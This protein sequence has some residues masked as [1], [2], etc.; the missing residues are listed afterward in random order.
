[1]LTLTLRGE[2]D[3]TLAVL[4]EGDDGRSR[5]ATLGILKNPG[6]LS[7]GQGDTLADEHDR[8][9]R[10]EFGDR[11]GKEKECGERLSATET[12]PAGL[13]PG[14]KNLLTLLVVPRSIPL[15]E[16]TQGGD[17]SASASF[18]RV[19]CRGQPAPDCKKG[20]T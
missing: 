3:E 11:R 17:V 10:A 16:G 6:D 20:L 19:A 2:S 8:W 9:R 4:G 15:R 5:A 18:W 7:L 1:M 12:G 14:G 13:P